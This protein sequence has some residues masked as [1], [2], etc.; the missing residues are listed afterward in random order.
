MCAIVD[1]QVSHEVFGANGPLAG[2]KFF[3]WIIDQESSRL[4]AGGKL[5][6]ELMNSGDGFRKWAK[7]ALLS[8]R[9][10]MLNDM[11]VNKMAARIEAEEEIKSDD[12]HVLAVA[13][14]SGA[15]LLFSNDHRLHKDF[16][17]NKLINNPR[18]KIYSTLKNRQF[19]T[20]HRR[21]LSRNACSA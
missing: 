16:T 18:G 12:P 13:R 20:E 3:A 14:I 11:R 9:L 1:A 10:I 5:M 8:G 4:V 7:Q 15:R 19:T 21:L 6:D 17:N 2:I